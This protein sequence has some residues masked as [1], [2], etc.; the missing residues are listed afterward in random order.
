MKKYRLCTATAKQTKFSYGK[1]IRSQ[2]EQ[3]CRVYIAKE[4]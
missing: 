4:Q 1:E 2:I 3:F